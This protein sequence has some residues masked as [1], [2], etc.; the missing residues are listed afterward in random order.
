MDKQDESGE[1]DRK[2]KELSNALSNYNKP[3]ITHIP[4]DKSVD[5]SEA[6]NQSWCTSCDNCKYSQTRTKDYCYCRILGG[7][8][9]RNNNFC[10][11]HSSYKK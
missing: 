1:I 3:V 4:I 9:R 11:N 2:A 5:K 6:T 10:I 8:I 7:L